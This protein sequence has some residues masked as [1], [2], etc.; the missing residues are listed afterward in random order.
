MEAFSGQ[1]RWKAE[2]DLFFSLKT[3]LRRA[4]LTGRVGRGFYYGAHPRAWREKEREREK[5]ALKTN[6]C[7]G[8]IGDEAERKPYFKSLK[9]NPIISVRLSR[10]ELRVVNFTPQVET[11]A[12]ARAAPRRLRPVA[13]GGKSAALRA[14]EKAGSSLPGGQEA[15]PSG[16]AGRDAAPDAGPK[17]PLCPGGPGLKA[18]P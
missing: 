4:G 8:L 3:R 17:A 2:Q 12:A 11:Q 13:E 5:G 16:E 9:C 7:R 15:F 6:L 14:Q 1:A 10:A 18:E